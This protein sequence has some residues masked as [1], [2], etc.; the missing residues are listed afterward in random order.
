MSRRVIIAGILAG[1]ALFA[2]GAVSHMVLGLGEKTMK[3]LP[4]EAAVLTTLQDG[5]KEPGIYVFPGVGSGMGGQPLNEAKWQ[6]AYRTMPHGLLVA[7]PPDGP[8]N[9]ERA[10]GIQVAT[11]VLCGVLA[12]FFLASTA[13]TSFFGRVLF[14]AELGAFATLAIDVP[15]WNWYGFPM[16]Y[17]VSQLVDQGIGWALAGVVLAWRLRPRP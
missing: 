17:L 10:L 15:Y 16:R 3:V 6:E 4:N 1:L 13:I 8:L 2:W 5:V 12:A 14:V 7:T 11:D 9:M